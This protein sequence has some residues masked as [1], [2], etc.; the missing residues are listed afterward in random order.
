LTYFEKEGVA[1]E[2]RRD[3]PAIVR[4]I[5][6]R[7]AILEAIPLLTV[8]DLTHNG[9]DVAFDLMTAALELTTSWNYICI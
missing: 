4:N 1:S 5:F 6:R 9:L 3:E 8:S 7:F 2:E